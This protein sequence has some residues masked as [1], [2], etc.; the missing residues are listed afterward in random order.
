MGCVMSMER[1]MILCMVIFSVSFVALTVYAILT[2][3]QIRRTARA[4]EF[5]AH[6]LNM[7]LSKVG[8][9]TS[10][11]S[12]VSDTL[13]GM[14]G[15]VLTFA[16]GAVSSFLKCNKKEENGKRSPEA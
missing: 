13:G 2:L 14:A 6:Q 3:V 15:K 11:V 7:E 16:M 5:L 10:F 4:V 12:G 1:Y 8:R 9:V